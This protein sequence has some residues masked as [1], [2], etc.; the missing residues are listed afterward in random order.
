MHKHF[1]YDAFSGTRVLVTGATGFIGQ[2]LCAA[3]IR[4]DAQVYG[5]RRPGNSPRWWSLD[6]GR[7]TWLEADLNDR[8][9]LE[10]VVRPIQATHIIHLAAATSFERGPHGVERMIDD[11]L[12]GT[13]HLLQVLD[14]TD[15]T[16]FI[17]TGSAE[18]YGASVA[19]FHEDASLKPVSPYSASKAA[20]SLFCDMFHRTLGWP[21]VVIR[22]FL[23]YGPGQP[24]DKL[25]PQAILAALT[26]QPLRITS[27]RQTREFTYIE[28]LIDGYLRAAMTKDAIGQTINL[29][30]GMAMPVVEIVGK[31]IEMTGSAITPEV[32]ALPDRPG[33]I[34]SYVCDNSRAGTLLGWSPSISLEQGLRITID[35]YRQAIDQGRL[36][37]DRSPGISH[38]RNPL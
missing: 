29:G 35:W 27:G 30:T 19:P 36:P 26:N 20:T 18:E 21:T 23:V 28:D 22:P 12:L 9:R 4:A 3:L 37:L 15:Y 33:E 34:M 14:G 10:S 17:Q 2:H 16:C 13:M 25:I 32:G 8:R 24:T 6:P 38:S 11:N 7:M 31:I 1:P 5:L